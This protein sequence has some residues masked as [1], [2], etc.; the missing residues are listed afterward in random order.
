MDRSLAVGLE[1]DFV[2][3]RNGREGTESRG[4]SIGTAIVRTSTAL[5]NEA[6]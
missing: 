6:G 4:A 2:G 3:V 1:R 5:S